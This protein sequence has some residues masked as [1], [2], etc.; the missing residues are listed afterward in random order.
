[1]TIKEAALLVIQTSVMAKGGDVF[2]LDMG[3]PVKIIDLARQMI[4]LS[5]LTEKKPDHI[6]G[7]IEIKI[8]G[9]RA[10]EKLYEELLINAESLPTNHPLIFRAQENSLD[11]ILLQQKLDKLEKLLI[12][13]KTNQVFALL[14]D[15]VKEWSINDI[16][17]DQ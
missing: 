10:G 15:L 12:N 1:M 14:K 11:P 9:L 2:L 13:N 4:T 3:K 5:G 16:K 6:N 8:S 7:D 17:I